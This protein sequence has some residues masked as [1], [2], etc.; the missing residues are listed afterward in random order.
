MNEN[1]NIFR[2]KSAWRERVKENWGDKAALHLHFADGFTL[3]ALQDNALVGLLSVQM[4]SLPAPLENCTEAFIDIIEVV[5]E[6]RRRQLGARMVKFAGD[7]ALEKGVYQIRA[8]SSEDKSEAIPFWRSLGFG[9][10]P[11]TVHHQDLVI[12]GFYITKV[13]AM[14]NHPEESDRH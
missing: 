7:L 1:L 10:A 2:A 12:R 6:Y 9:L 3:L 4:R 14:E 5:Y 11:A 8:W 13:L